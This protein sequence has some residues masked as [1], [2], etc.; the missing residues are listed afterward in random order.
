[1]EKIQERALRFIYH[2]YDMDYD[3]LL[4]KSK[5]PT[6]HVR[7]VRTL[8]IETY[9]LINKEGPKYLHDLITLKS[10]HYSCRNVLQTEL[11]QVQTSRYG[12]QSFRYVAAKLWNSLPNNI[13]SSS[14]FGMFKNM[15]N[16][17]E[18]TTCQCTACCQTL[19]LVSTLLYF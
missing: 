13:K 4:A 7:R 17:W 14:S 16:K 18:G 8:A 9:K 10:N 19:Y 11:P 3:S 2:D 12:L 15:I 6:L 1:M 5:L